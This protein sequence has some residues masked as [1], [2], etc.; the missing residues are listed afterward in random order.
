MAA[1]DYSSSALI[2][3]IRTILPNLRKSE[4][5]VANYIIQHPDEVIYLS[6]AA[7]AENC[8]VSEPTVIRTCRGLGFSGYQDL[9]VTLAQSIATPLAANR[10]EILPDDDMSQVINKVFNETSHSLQYTHDT[11]G[12]ESMQKAVEALSSARRIYIFGL[13]GSAPVAMDFQHKLLRFGLNATA[14]TD[15][16]LQAICGAYCTSEDLVFAISHSGSSLNVVKNTKKAKEHS[17]KVVTLTN[18]GRS[19]LS[20]LADIALFTASDETKYR[21][22]ALSSRIAELTILDSLY[23]YM[24]IRSENIKS[25]KVEKAMEDLKY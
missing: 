24:A 21:I 4:Q 9:K 17:A 8:S 5:T 20:K 16:H 1:Q 6:V 11:I 18:L 19:P 13:G 25:M 12:V 14:F 3:K 7:L 15:P 23:T 10:E 22:V 2:L